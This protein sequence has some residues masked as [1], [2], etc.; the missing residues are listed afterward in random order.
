MGAKVGVARGGRR[1]EGCATRKDARGAKGTAAARAAGS[2]GLVAR[3]GLEGDERPLPLVVV[4]SLMA[5]VTNGSVINILED[6]KLCAC[7]AC[8]HDQ[9]VLIEDSIPPLIPQIM[10][11]Y[12]I[13]VYPYRI[14]QKEICNF[15]I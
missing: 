13:L 7:A 2:W 1:H 14:P 12:Q 6:H 10:L 9:L 4:S 15:Q 5:H 3:D 11:Q 8:I